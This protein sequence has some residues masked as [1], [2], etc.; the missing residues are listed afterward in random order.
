MT[1]F[2]FSLR[3]LLFVVT[4]LAV[5]L[6]ALVWLAQYFPEIFFY[7]TMFSCAVGLLGFGIVVFAAVLLFTV[8][9]SDNT[10]ERK[11]NIAKC[12]NLILIGALMIALPLFS[13]LTTI[14]LLPIMRGR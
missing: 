8:Y 7:A 10:N 1:R 11:L 3:Q 4:L 14:S 12:A 13:A 6:G 2:S 9:V 5:A